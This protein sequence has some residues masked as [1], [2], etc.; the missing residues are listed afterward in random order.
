MELYRVS[1]TTASRWVD[2]GK[3]DDCIARWLNR[4]NGFAVT[5][6]PPDDVRGRGDEIRAIMESHQVS[7]AT[8]RRWLQSGDVERRADLYA[9]GKKASE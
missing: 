6:Q 9:R 4:E 2:S 1:F 7:Y 3:Q 5:P 8:A